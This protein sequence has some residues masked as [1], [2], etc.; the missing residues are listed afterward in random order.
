M[1]ALYIPGFYADRLSPDVDVIYYSLPVTIPVLVL[2]GQ[3]DSFFP[4]KA[5]A[6]SPQER[7]EP[8]PA[9]LLSVK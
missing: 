5:P 1:A 7:S 8:L 6:D 2:N 4:E 9:D 3:Y